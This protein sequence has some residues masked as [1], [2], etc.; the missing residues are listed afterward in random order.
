MKRVKLAP[1]DPLSTYVEAK[2]TRH[3]YN[4]V[5]S[6]D[7][8]VF[9]SYKVIQLAKKDYYT[10]KD[11]ITVNEISAEVK[12]QELLNHTVSRLVESQR[13]VIESQKNFCN[14][15]LITKWGFDGSSGHS[16]YKQRL[17]SPSEDDASVFITLLVPLRLISGDPEGH[18]V[19]LWQNPRSSSI[20]FCRPIRFQL[21]H[22]TS[23]IAKKEKEYMDQQ[24]QS[25]VPSTIN[26]TNLN[27]KINHIL[28]FTMME[29]YVIQSQKQHL[30]R[31]VPYVV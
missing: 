29:K 3:Q 25:L 2:L 10:N 19:I 1:E 23:E 11:G 4:V 12:L 15:H 5:K 31:N 8:L 30:V 21:K 28:L 7:I 9:P 22:E 24:I 17:H 26:L 27:I 14:L 20:R 16:R 6:K 13:Q 18:H